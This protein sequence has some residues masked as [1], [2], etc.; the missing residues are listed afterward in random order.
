M[1]NEFKTAVFIM[2]KAETEIDDT[3]DLKTSE[4]FFLHHPQLHL[5]WSPTYPLSC[6]VAFW[7]H[8]QFAIRSISV[9]KTQFYHAVAI[10]PRDVATQILDLIRAPLA[11]DPYKVLREHLITHIF[12]VYISGLYLEFIFKVYIY[13]LYKGFI[14]GVYI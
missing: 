4:I 2:S 11:G 3:P 7:P 13:G 1:N 14:L 10:F 9:S 8:A 12:R 6:L 5:L